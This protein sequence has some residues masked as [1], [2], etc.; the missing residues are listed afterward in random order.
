M[1][2]DASG[3]CTC[4][5]GHTGK[6][7]EQCKL[8]FYGFPSCKGMKYFM[9]SDDLN[10]LMG[11]L[12]NSQIVNAIWR[13]QSIRFVIM[14]V[15]VRA[16]M[17]SMVIDAPDANPTCL[18]S[19]IVKVIFIV[20]TKK[21]WCSKCEPMTQ[22]SRESLEKVEMILPP[23]QIAD[24]TQQVQHHQNVKLMDNVNVRK[25]TV[26]KNATLDVQKVGLQL[27]IPAFKC[28]LILERILKRPIIV[29]QQ[30]VLQLNQEAKLK[31]ML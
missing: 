10:L 29:V 24:V 11:N 2:C 26:D 7:C 4:S 22:E 25:V 16:K 27:A 13:D 3:Q 12:L 1:A 15:F 8:G 17:E 14:M 20:S 9:F 23:V 5:E 19:Q 30:E 21:V 28:P 31:M 18:A 6:K